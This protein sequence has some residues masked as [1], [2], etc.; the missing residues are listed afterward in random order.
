M[1]KTGKNVKPVRESNQAEIAEGIAAEAAASEAKE[2]PAD[3][4]GNKNSSGKTELVFILDASGSMYELASDTRGGFNSLLRQQRQSGAETLVSTVLF[5][6]GLSLLHD[7]LPI[8][9]VPEMTETDYLPSGCTALVDAIGSSI[10]HIRN[11]HRYARPEDL[12]AHTLF[13]IT[14]DGLENA[15][16]YY[17]A[18]EVRDMVRTQSKDAG[19]EFIFLGADMDTVETA[20]FYGIDRSRAARY[21]NDPG[22]TAKK[23]AA[24]AVA[25]NDVKAGLSLNDS[26]W[27]SEL[28]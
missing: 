18:D 23:F 6:S 16:R 4:G 19:W 25:I 2:G 20:E 17:S 13:V 22:G 8:G 1:K 5:N 11:I 3:T 10:R 21:S 12:P 14:T 28:L 7:R 26:L 27:K 15:S 24:A 9:D